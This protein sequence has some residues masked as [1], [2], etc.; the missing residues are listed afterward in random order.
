MWLGT[1]RCRSLLLVG[2]NAK[3]GPTQHLKPSWITRRSVHDL[4]DAVTCT[5][6][7]TGGDHQSAEHRQRQG[8]ASQRSPGV[9]SPGHVVRSWSE[10]AGGQA[11]R[12]ASS[13]ARGIN[14]QQPAAPRERRAKES[15]P[16]SRFANRTPIVSSRRRGSISLRHMRSRARPEPC[17]TPPSM[18]PHHLALTWEDSAFVLRKASRK[19]RN[20]PPEMR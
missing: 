7:R 13:K 1:S 18:A 11:Q 4:N 12:R 15:F 14:Q 2:D 10:I 5:L 16:F 19:I 9:H 8:P 3:S 17:R 20:A 6:R